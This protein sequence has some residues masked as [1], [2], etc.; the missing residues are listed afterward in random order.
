MIVRGNRKGFE[1]TFRAISYSYCA[2]LFSIIPLIGSFIGGIYFFVL[3][4]IGVREGHNIST[5]KAVLAVLLPLIIFVGLVILIT[6]F[7][8]SFIIGSLG[9]LRGVGV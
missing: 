1:A 9:S 8:I 2:Q 6:V 3:A 7:F 5:G 4:I